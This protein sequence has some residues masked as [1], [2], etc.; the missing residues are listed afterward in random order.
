MSASETSSLE[1]DEC[2]PAPAEA[3]AD[4]P[5]V[6]LRWLQQVIFDECSSPLPP[7]PTPA[8]PAVGPLPV[9]KPKL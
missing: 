7:L 8:E 2:P 5:A 3:A 1:P 6:A 4:L 9:R